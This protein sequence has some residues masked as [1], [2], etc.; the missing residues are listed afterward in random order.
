MAK[1]IGHYTTH[2]FIGSGAFG[3]V[4]KAAK[5]GSD[6]WFAIKRISKKSI[7]RT[8]MAEQVKKEISIMKT[9]DHPNIVRTEEVLMSEKYVFICM[10]HVE[11]GELS[12]KVA[13]VGRLS[14]DLAS[15]FTRQLC[16]V[17][18]FCHDQKICHRDIKPQNI[19]LDGNNNVKL[20]DF[21]FA[22]F[23]EV[24]VEHPEDASF[25][26]DN[27]HD[28]RT[29]DVPCDEF[30]LELSHRS[31]DVTRLKKMRTYCGTIQYM[32]PEISSGGEYFGDKV[33]MWAIGMVVYFMFI[34]CLPSTTTT[35]ERYVRGRVPVFLEKVYRHVPGG[36]WDV[37]RNLLVLEDDRYSATQCLMLPWLQTGDFDDDSDYVERSVRVI[38]E[39]SEEDDSDSD[40]DTEFSILVAENFDT[41]GKTI[42]DYVGGVLE[43]QEYT[44]NIIVS[45][46]K[47]RMSIDTSTDVAYLVVSVIEQ[48]DTVA[49]HIEKI[50]GE[51]SSRK[52]LIVKAALVHMQAG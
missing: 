49:V 1:R 24:E 27:I 15:R 13:S 19:L 10:E 3:S 8:S 20:A 29:M 45:N 50:S 33:D 7:L 11:G 37:L 46:G 26:V 36:A 42:I 41:D 2:E 21:G 47:I 51:C 31:T 16:E 43:D 4:I 39:V 22:S 52:M 25:R 30:I 28:L 38:S 34:G 12:S 44:R 6:R 32:A 35:A 5:K 14:D 40:S 17:M 18:K 48:G 23:M 9:L